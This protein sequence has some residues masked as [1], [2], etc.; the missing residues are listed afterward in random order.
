MISVVTDEDGKVLFKRLQGEGSS[1]IAEFIALKEAI[2]YCVKKGIKQTTIITDSRNNTFWF[3][4]LKRGNQNN[5]ELVAEI[6]KEIM[7]LRKSVEVDL[8]WESRETNLAGQY[9]EDNYAL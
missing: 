2:S 9:I 5:Y 6:R 7:K 1:N 4:R 8:I 3:K